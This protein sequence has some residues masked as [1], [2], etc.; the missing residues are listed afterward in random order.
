M[1]KID[2]YNVLIADDE[3][4]IRQSLKRRITETDDSY[5]IAAECGD[6]REAL[7]ALE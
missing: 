4:M 7:K 6:G 1:I 3:Y 5:R 2:H